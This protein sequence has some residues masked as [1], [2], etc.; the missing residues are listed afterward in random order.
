MQERDKVV[1]GIYYLRNSHHKHLDNLILTKSGLLWVVSKV[2]GSIWSQ[3]G[4]IWDQNVYII[5]LYNVIN[6]FRP[7]KSG[8]SNLRRFYSLFYLFKIGM[9]KLAVFGGIFGGLGNE[10][11]RGEQRK[12]WNA[13]CIFNLVQTFWEFG[14]CPDYCITNSVIIS[15]IPS[16][17]FDFSHQSILIIP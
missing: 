12:L 11:K 5:L 15:K 7:K 10:A 13:F 4:Q 16:S 9:E 2:G 1:W 6:R 8:K 17:I 3:G 14:R